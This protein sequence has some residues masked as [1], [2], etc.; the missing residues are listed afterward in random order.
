MS[1]MA[2]GVRGQAARHFPFH[3][4]EGFKTK[5]SL[6]VGVWLLPDL[7]HCRLDFVGG[8]G[9]TFNLWGTKSQGGKGA[10]RRRAQGRTETGPFVVRV[11]CLEVDCGACWPQS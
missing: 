11:S 1:G 6:D 3:F 2:A 10:T 5:Q 7:L 8:H 4:G 9:V